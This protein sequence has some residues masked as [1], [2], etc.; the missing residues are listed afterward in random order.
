MAQS[1]DDRFRPRPGPPR[2][3]GDGGERFVSL[4]RRQVAKAGQAAGRSTR[5]SQFGRGRVAARLRSRSPTLRSRRV[6]ITSRFVMVKPGS[7]AIA[8]HLRYI[9][10]DGVTRDGERGQA[11]GAQ[12][13]EADTRAVVERSQ[14]DRHQFRFILSSEDA[15][16]LGDLRTFTR[17]F[18]QRMEIDLQTR[19]DWVAVDHWDTDNP[20][21][22]IV[23]RGRADNRQDL[24]IAPEYMSH[25]MRERAAEL[26]TEWLG[27]RTE[28][29]IADTLQREIQQGRFTTLDRS[30]LRMAVEADSMGASNLRGDS[31]YQRALAARLQHLAGMGLAHQMDDDRY[32]LD[33][34]ME[35]TL[36]S[37]G[38]RGDILRAMHRAMRN[39]ARE[40]VIETGPE[41][42]QPIIGRIAD[43]GLANELYDKG[44]IVI[45]GADG[46]VHYLALAPGMVLADFPTGGIVEVRPIPESAADKNIAKRAIGGIYRPDDHLAALEEMQ[47]RKE[48]DAATGQRGGKAWDTRQD[49]ARA[50]K[51]EAIVRSH[52]MRLES[53]RRAEIVERLDD[54]TWKVPSD[55]IK[56]GR[57][58]DLKMRHGINVTVRSHLPLARQIDVPGA[59]WLDRKL[60]DGGKELTGE[61]FGGEVQEAMQARAA[62]LEGEG[63]A[64]R[65]EERVIVARGL[66]NTLRDREVAATAQRIATETGLAYQPLG[67]DG[68]ASGVYRRSVMLASGRYAVLDDGLGFTLVPWRPIVEHHL[69]QSVSAT[70]QAGRVT[71]EFG[72]QRGKSI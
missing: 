13:D 22:H 49:K 39:H 33:A 35:A 44:Y 59:T 70:L 20:H 37:L 10:R 18:M 50:P 1:D 69:G 25:G 65:Q 29:E 67:E 23:L 51:P 46:R 63:L 24:V 27:P 48:R 68:Q 66:L 21:T 16:E 40:C 2:Q 36:R 58:H 8:A 56:R 54:D 42:R 53:L 11:Y 47:A 34:K 43:K 41:L 60:I 52:V 55:L 71:W 5:G 30:L 26:A 45:D 28:R 4:V 64:R 38:E 6:V 72:R 62:Y 7:D 31:P 15:A 17:T 3:R 19:L 32:Q 57:E 61:G 12:T 9:E 14:G